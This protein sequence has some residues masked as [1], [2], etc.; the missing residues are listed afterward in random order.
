MLPLDPEIYGAL[1]IQSAKEG[2][3]V[4]LLANALLDYGLEEVVSGKAVIAGGSRNRESEAH[5][6]HF[7]AGRRAQTALLKARPRSSPRRS[8]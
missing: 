4:Q 6:S 2:V 7:A 1:E 3:D 5:V 8:R